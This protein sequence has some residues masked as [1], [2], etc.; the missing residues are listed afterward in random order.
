MSRK[1]KD[2]SKTQKY[3]QG[4]MKRSKKNRFGVFGWP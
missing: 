3:W 4:G 1:K 2:D